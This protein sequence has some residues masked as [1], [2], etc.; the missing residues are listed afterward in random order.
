MS[1]DKPLETQQAYAQAQAYGRDLARL[2]A[3]EKERRKKLEITSQKLQAIFDTVPTGLAVIDHNLTLIEANP[4]FFALFEQKVDCIGQ[5]LSNFLPTEILLKSMESVT[6]TIDKGN[7]VCE[8]YC[9]GV[10]IGTNNFV[11]K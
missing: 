8:I 6:G 4:R 5:P 9:E 1:D 3:L 10:K 11:L 2:Y 7:Y